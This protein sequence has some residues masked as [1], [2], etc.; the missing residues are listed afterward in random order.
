MARVGDGEKQL[1]R[2]EHVY[3]FGVFNSPFAKHGINFVSNFH[4]CN[5]FKR[6]KRSSTGSDVECWEGGNAMRSV[7]ETKS[8]FVRG[9]RWIVAWPLGDNYEKVGKCPCLEKLWFPRFTEPFT[10]HL[11]NLPDIFPK[12]LHKTLFQVSK[13][14]LPP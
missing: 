7:Q 2:R 8:L 11:L 14:P 12:Q 5:V 9:R 13:S 3:G 6:R 10:K 1:R 4:V